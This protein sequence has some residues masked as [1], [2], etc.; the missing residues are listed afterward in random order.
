MMPNRDEPYIL[1]AKAAEEYLK[2]EGVYAATPSSSSLRKKNKA[3]EA[4]YA[5]IAAATAESKRREVESTRM[6]HLVHQT[7][8]RLGSKAYSDLAS[9]LKGE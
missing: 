9:D 4:L 3:R 6:R 8:E 1:L 7:L 2:A 5:A